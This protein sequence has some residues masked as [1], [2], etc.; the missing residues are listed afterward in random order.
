[1]SAYDRLEDAKASDKASMNGFS[2]KDESIDE[3]ASALLEDLSQSI[4]QTPVPMSASSPNLLRFTSGNTVAE[5][6]NKALPPLPQDHQRAGVFHHQRARTALS[7]KTTMRRVS[8][9]IS[10]RAEKRATKLPISSPVGPILHTGFAPSAIER[11]HTPNDQS[12]HT[13]GVSSPETTTADA[14]DLSEKISN[15]IKQANEQNK[16]LHPKRNETANS[17]NGDKLSALSKSKRAFTKAKQAVVRRFSS[18]AEKQAKKKDNDNYSLFDTTFYDLDADIDSNRINRRIAEGHNL[19]SPKVRSLTGDGNVPRKALPVYDS[20]KSKRSIAPDDPFS[21][22]MEMKDDVR[23]SHA[24]STFDSDLSGRKTNKASTYTDSV[25]DLLTAQEQN[26]PRFSDAVSGLAQH[27]DVDC[28]SSSPLGHSTPRIRLEPRIDANGK[29][30]LTGVL[31]HSPSITNSNFV[32]CDEGNKNQSKRAREIEPHDLRLKRKR[33][34]TDLRPSD[35]PITKKAKKGAKSTM[36][37]PTVATGIGKL[38][39]EDAGALASKDTNRKI[40]RA[41]RINKGKGLGIF[42]TGKR[43]APMTDATDMVQKPRGRLAN[44]A[45][46]SSIPKPV[47][48]TPGYERRAITIPSRNLTGDDSMGVDELQMD[49]SEYH[50]GGRRG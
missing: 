33:L 17:K 42:D 6:L 2:Q 40:A 46:R 3:L 12:E 48:H 36:E 32:A 28:F 49:V 9:E 19:S 41:S 15:L 26:T 50:I 45:K 25:T 10:S 4:A 24:Y 43:E 14:A 39:T 1:M 7:S 18:S 11:V 31:N 47:N 8:S 34:T 13:T 44:V 16:G 37:D 29:K 38:D 21:D 35:I 27:P 30:R 22:D 20:I 5:D 23:S